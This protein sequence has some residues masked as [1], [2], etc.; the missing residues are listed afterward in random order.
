MARSRRMSRV[1]RL[2]IFAGCVEER[3]RRAKSRTCAA[4]VAAAVSSAVPAYLGPST[5]WIL[6]ASETVSQ[7]L[8]QKG[9]PQ[10]LSAESFLGVG[11]SCEGTEW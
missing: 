7:T 10:A 11:E 2:A 5:I 9:A 3:L 8:T 4:I 1:G 6:P